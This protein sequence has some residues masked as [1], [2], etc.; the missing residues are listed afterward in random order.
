M[1]ALVLKDS[2]ND[3]DEDLLWSEIWDPFMDLLKKKK[4]GS[5]S[6]VVVQYW[7]SDSKKDYF[8]L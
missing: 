1:F 8:F 4:N 5:A 3:G 2:D 7:F 6:E